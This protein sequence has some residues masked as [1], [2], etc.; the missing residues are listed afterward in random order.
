VTATEAQRRR[1]NDLF[2]ELCRIRSPFGHERACADRVAAEL[3]DIG[4]A[5]EEDGAGPE[6][7]SE[8]GN[9]L[10]RVPGSTECTLLLCAHLDTVVPQAPIDPV[11]EEGVWRNANPGILG[12][13]NKAAVAVMLE[14]ARHAVERGTEVGLELLFTVC[15]ENALRGAKAFDRTRL[16]ADCGYVFDHASP[17][18]EVVMASPSYFR[19]D[20]EFHGA[21]AHA[22]IRPEDGHNAVAAA[23]AAVAAMRL[24]R[25]DPETTANVGRIEGGSASLN[26]VPDRC[27]IEAET[28]SLDD[29]KVE[30]SV[31]EMV[32]RV[33]DGANA[34]EC[35]VDV[36]VEALFRGY[37]ERGTAP[38]VVAAEAALRASGFEPRRI[39][40]GG[41]SDANVLHAAGLP[42]TN[43]ANGTR[44]N[45]Q[46]DESVA[47][48]ALEDMLSVALRLPG[49]VREALAP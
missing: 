21:S 30:A 17:I 33:H 13:D 19:L 10:A 43:L 48:S 34:H 46:P 1:V 45:H 14:V 36:Q 11:V 26:V 4:V 7:G 12:A 42:V 27:R 35:D 29:A 44:A 2:A 20:A 5:V 32:D 9:L 25:L 22:G 3:R 47:A 16:R 31:T 6:A 28:R 23:A 8:C 40:T 49:A 38:A 37:R 41:G 24:G 18:G 39:V 15:E